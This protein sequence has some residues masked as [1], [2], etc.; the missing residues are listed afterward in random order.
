MS[1][2]GFCVRN[3]FYRPLCFWYPHRKMG[4][5]V[6]SR[7]CV[8]IYITVEVLSYNVIVLDLKPTDPVKS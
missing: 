7:V 4:F 5:S 8:E 2:T 6:C 1:T 3:G